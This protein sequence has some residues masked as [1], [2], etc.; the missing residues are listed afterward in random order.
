MEKYDIIIENGASICY[1]RKGDSISALKTGG[2]IKV[3]I[4]P[5][6]IKGLI[7]ALENTSDDRIVL[8]YMTNTLISDHGIDKEVIH[9]SAVKGVHVDGDKLICATGESLSNACIVARKFGLTGMENLSGIPGS[10]GGAV[11][12]NAGAF[13]TFMSDIVECA[14]VFTD[15]KVVSM[16]KEEL[17][18]SYRHSSILD[19]G[20]VVLEIVLKLAHCNPIIIASTMKEARIKRHLSQ[21]LEVSLGSAFKRCDDNSAGYYIEK[22]GLKGFSI[23]DAEVSKKHANFII[24]K[25][26]C[27]SNDYFNLMCHIQKTVEKECNVK[28]QR[29]VRLIGEFE[30]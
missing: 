25:G 29:E 28:L 27:T 19:N 6:T 15:G 13:G 21:P 16:T 26:K 5:N 14:K 18:M 10:V 20:D 22:C 12:M 30:E 23:G 4:K 1:N 9:T 8:G 3:L 24:N 7:V 11:A 2:R 17:C